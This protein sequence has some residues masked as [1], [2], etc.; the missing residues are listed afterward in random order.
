MS[1]S[2]A[3]DTIE[4][5]L[6]DGTAEAYLA[7]PDDG[8][9]HPGVLLYMDAYGLRPW[10]GEI[11]KTIAAQGFTV[12]APNVFYRTWSLADAPEVDF[13]KS[14]T[15]FF[16]ALAPA[17]EQLTPEA[18]MRDAGGYLAW[19]DASPLVA[20]APYATLGYCMGGRLA[21]RVATEFGDRIAAAASFHGGRLAADDLPDSPHH[22]ADRISAEVLAAH[23]DN[24]SS[25]DA[26]AIERFEKALTEAGVTFTS[27]VYPDAQHG[28]T[29]RDTPAYQEAG[30]HRHLDDLLALLRRKFP[31]A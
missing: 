3:F 30:Y 1:A 28:F 23:A 4:I 26:E 22:K 8:A 27:V 20:P 17:R 29:M 24:D 31:S 9:A 25:M 12:I 15:A 18:A 21:L 14:H 11:V 5:A 13:D 6:S 2:V 16:A 10:L 19:L 7:H